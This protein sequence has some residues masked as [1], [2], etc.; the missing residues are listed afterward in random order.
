MRNVVSQAR[1][2]CPFCRAPVDEELLR[3]GGHCPHCLI[4]IPGEEAPTDP[5]A[6]HKEPRGR[7]SLLRTVALVGVFGLVAVGGIGT[8]AWS[9]FAPGVPDE[10]VVY[11][12]DTYVVPLSAHQDLEMPVGPE[13]PEASI[14]GRRTMVKKRTI[15]PTGGASIG[16]ED[17]V[18]SSA[19]PTESGRTV[20]APE[21]L[22]G[23]L[24]LESAN[25]ED[26]TVGTR[27]RSAGPQAIVLEDPAQIEEMIGRVL[28]LGTR[29][30]QQC[31]EQRLKHNANIGGSWELV[32]TVGTEGL[33]TNVAAV[34]MDRDDTQ[35][36]GCLVRQ[37]QGWTFQRI[38]QP[39]PVNWPLLLGG[40]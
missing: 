26:F 8:A 19:L 35:L 33:A 18:A 4:D 30:L 9:H 32:F 17:A 38:K 21:G 40:A 20:D 25:L 27:P 28:H 37:V 29:Q 36:A 39:A 12:F 22:R 23:G 13:D 2:G 3:F 14:Q 16:R 10:E 31:Y 1:V 15:H 6:G 11:Q 24:S 7:G 5:G 34:A